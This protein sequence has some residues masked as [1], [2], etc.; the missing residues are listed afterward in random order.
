MP[1]LK[2]LV[3]RTHDNM[4][5]YVL[6][7]LHKKSAT[8]ILNLKKKTRRR[9]IRTGGCWGLVPNPPSMS[10]NDL[11]QRY[12][13]NKQGRI[14]GKILGLKFFGPTMG[15]VYVQTLK[16]PPPLIPMGKAVILKIKLP[17]T[18][19]SKWIYAKVDDF[20]N[21]NSIIGFAFDPLASGPKEMK[22]GNSI[23][24][25]EI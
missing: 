23:W 1:Y 10:Q 19:K 2:G 11:A 15:C 8:R 16:R 20:Q 7:D 17:E 12:R 5:V 18:N 4:R 14:K 25:S 21:E 9:K 13:K 24:I 6:R 3:N 22:I